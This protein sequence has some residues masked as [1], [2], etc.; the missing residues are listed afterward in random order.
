MN[1]YFW[2]L[3]PKLWEE[4]MI[5]FLPGIIFIVFMEHRWQIGSKYKPWLTKES[6]RLHNGS[7]P[8]PGHKWVEGL[9]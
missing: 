9:L 7:S 2:A 8:L 4:A 5:L 3:A 1:V 6:S